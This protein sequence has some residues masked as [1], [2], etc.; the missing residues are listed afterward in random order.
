M[1]RGTECEGLKHLTF[2]PG[3]N[4]SLDWVSLPTSLETLVFGEDFDQSLLWL[5][6]PNLHS[7]SAKV[8]D[9]GSASI[10]MFGA[11]ANLQLKDV[12]WDRSQV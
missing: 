6:L 4:Q 5:N 10:C 7:A 3:F 1:F 11:S 2:G 9:S 12:E 8:W